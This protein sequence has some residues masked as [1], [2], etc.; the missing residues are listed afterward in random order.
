MSIPS[1][2][3]NVWRGVTGQDTDTC[4]PAAL[5]QI[6]PYCHLSPDTYIAYERF[7]RGWSR[8]KKKDPWAVNPR[9]KDLIG[10]MAL[11]LGGADFDEVEFERA[12][13]YR[14]FSTMVRKLLRHEYRVAID[15]HLDGYGHDTAHPVGLIPFDDGESFKLV[16]TWVPSFLHGAVSLRDVFE[17]IDF[18]PEPYRQRFPFND[19]NITALPP[20]EVLDVA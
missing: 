6:S 5:E 19:S 16:S 8:L 14:E 15:I 1:Y 7:M 18:H 20:L 12:E 3:R 17:N 13:T 4:F 11:E 10:Q 2:R 9:Y